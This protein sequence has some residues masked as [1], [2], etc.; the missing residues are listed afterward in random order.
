MVLS[1]FLIKGNALSMLVRSDG[2]IIQQR[3]FFVPSE[4]IAF[5]FL[6]WADPYDRA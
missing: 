3:A 1:D 5:T 2:V 6:S 4:M